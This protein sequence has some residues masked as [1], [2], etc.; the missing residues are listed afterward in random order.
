MSGLFIHQAVAASVRR[1][2]GKVAVS[3]EGRQ[4]T[5]AELWDDACRLAGAL[6]DG[7]GLG[8][9]DRVG[10]MMANRPEFYVAVLAVSSA[11]L[12]VVPVPVGATPRELEHFV[13]DSG[14]RLLV[15]EHKVAERLGD[16]LVQL[17]GGGLLVGVW[18]EPFEGGP[19]V[20]DLVAGGS[21]TTAPVALDESAPFFFGYTSGTTGAPKA[22]VVSHRARTALALLHGQEYG[23]YTVADRTLVVT[24]M[25]HSAGMSR[26]LV[27]LITGG[28]ATLHRHFD[29]EECVATLADGLHTGVFM[30]PTMFA[31]IFEL[32]ETIWSKMA[33]RAV[34]ILSNAA[35]LPTYLKHRIV[36]AWPEV[37]LFEIYGSTEGGTVTSLRPEDQLRKERC[38]GPPLALTEVAIWDNDGNPVGDGEVGTLAS[39]SPFVFTHY[40]GNPSATA[41]AIRDGWVVAGDLA[42]RDEEGYVYIVGRSSEV[43]IS[44]GVNVYPREVEEVLAAHPAV[45]EVAVVGAPDDYWGERVHAVV[46][47]APGA[48]VTQEELTTHCRGL[49][50]PQKIPRSYEWRDSLPRTGTGKVAKYLLVPKAPSGE[51]GR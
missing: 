36:E 41:Q 13:T 17:S 42:R 6:R 3:F 7:L 50:A 5:Y 8:V 21:P 11:G 23:C 24:P 18:E 46:V 12:V 20:A 2:P 39:R 44:G 25:Y 35:A 9:G 19:S 45:R 31:A 33:S 22:A 30:V 26:A 27:P 34:T 43:V 29:P 32:D 14:M 38:V 28:T 47:L 51:K 37:R 10:I 4:I 1:R 16:A 49:L 15:T 40:H 48:Q